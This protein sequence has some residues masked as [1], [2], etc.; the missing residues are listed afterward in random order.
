MH[1]SVFR[2]GRL[3]VAMLVVI[4]SASGWP[5]ALAQNE[6]PADRATEPNPTPAALPSTRPETP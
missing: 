1:R 2:A 3:A 6:P 4:A 5:I